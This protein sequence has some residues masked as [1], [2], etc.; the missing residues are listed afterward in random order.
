MACAEGGTFF[1]YEPIDLPQNTRTEYN[2]YYYYYGWNKYF[3]GFLLP[4]GAIR[5]SWMNIYCDGYLGLNNWHWYNQSGS[6]PPS[7]IA[8]FLASDVDC[9]SYLEKNAGL[10]HSMHSVFPYSNNPEADAPILE[11][12]K[13]R[14][15]QDTNVE[16]DVKFAFIVTWK[17]GRRAINV[18]KNETIFSQVVLASDGNFTYAILNVGNHTQ[19][20]KIQSDN[21]IWSGFRI[22]D[23]LTAELFNFISYYRNYRFYGWLPDIGYGYQTVEYSD[24]LDFA[25]IA[26]QTGNTG[27]CTLTFTL[28]TMSLVDE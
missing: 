5:T 13:R 15:S 14:I 25:T 22:K 19:W 18:R 23:D 11:L 28:E 8:A 20:S 17:F 12:A 9:L 7:G 2:N 21:E 26:S 16:L 1:P 3:N 24:G 10:Y 4:I 27:L 6:G